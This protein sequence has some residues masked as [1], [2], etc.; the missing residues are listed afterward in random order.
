MVGASDIVTHCF[1][2]HPSKEYAAGMAHITH[3]RFGVVDSE[4]EMLGGQTVDK[5][6]C[7]FGEI[8]DDNDDAVIIPASFGGLARFEHAELHVDCIA[9]H[10][11]KP[12]IICDQDRLRGRVMLRLRQQ[13]SGDLVR[14]VLPIG[15]DKD[16]ARSCDHVDADNPIELALGLCDIGV[17]G[18]GDDVHRLDALCAVG[19]G[20]DG[21]RTPHAPD[22]VDP[23]HVRSSEH[24]RIRIALGRRCDD[25]N[26]LNA[27]DAGGDRIHQER[28]GI[29]SSAAGHIKA[30]CIDREPPCSQPHALIIS[31]VPICGQ[32][33]FVIGANATGR[34][35]ES[36]AL[37][38]VDLF[39]CFFA[40]FRRNDPIGIIDQRI[41]VKALR[42]LH[43]CFIAAG[44]H[45]AQNVR[46]NARNITF[47]FAPRIDDAV[48]ALF[49]IGFES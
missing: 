3:H 26:A 6:G 4:L 25:D 21:L 10:R 16:F 9:D 20:R 46:D 42:I 35:F 40:T 11:G 47:G 23:G 33:R 24:E 44:L 28:G 22:F 14:I 48:E 18:T 7:F 31:V 8:I 30:S 45:G 37:V 36:L 17:A 41:P 2:R 49:E 15:N 19:E 29:G 32:L 43:K 1:W 34:E 12:F 5:R 13:V 39:V 27:S 38:C